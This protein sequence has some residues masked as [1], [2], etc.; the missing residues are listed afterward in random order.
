MSK[1]IQIIK[2]RFKKE[3]MSNKKAIHELLT[4]ISVCGIFWIAIK[5]MVYFDHT[6]YFPFF[7]NIGDSITLILGAIWLTI[8]K[9]NFTGTPQK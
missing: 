1:I 9:N 8:R 6:V 5:F 7:P 3:Q 4:I 2:N